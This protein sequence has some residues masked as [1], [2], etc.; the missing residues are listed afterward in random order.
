MID[1]DVSRDILERATRGIFEMM[2]FMDVGRL[3]P[4]QFEK[5]DGDSLLSTITFNGQ[6][7][8]CFGFCCNRASANAVAASM[9]SLD[10]DDEVAKQDVN[11]AMGEIV[12]RVMGSI[13]A[14]EPT[15]RN[16]Q[17]SIPTVTRGQQ[18]EHNPVEEP[19]GIVDHVKIGDDFSAE[20]FLYWHTYIR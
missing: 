17:V 4:A 9:L 14:E 11:D 19:N 7:E 18:I 15:F 5:T 8:G 16:V 12:N 6:I 3:D 1:Q 10:P 20:L 13:K 2:V